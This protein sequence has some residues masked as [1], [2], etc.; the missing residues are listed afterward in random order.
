MLQKW[1]R[2]TWLVALS[3]AFLWVISM[4]LYILDDQSVSWAVQIFP[5][6]NDILQTVYFLIW[7][8]M[9]VHFG[10][11]KSNRYLLIST[12]HFV[13]WIFIAVGAYYAY[14]TTA[15]PG[16]FKFFARLH[17]FIFPAMRGFSFYMLLFVFLVHH[18]LCFY[19]RRA[20]DRKITAKDIVIP[21]CCIVLTAALFI[22]YAITAYR[23]DCEKVDAYER[24][25]FAREYFYYSDGGSALYRGMGYNIMYW[26]KLS[27]EP[28]IYMCGNER[29]FFWEKSPDLSEPNVEL[30]K[31]YD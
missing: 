19:F 8:V 1:S 6:V 15:G 26:H 23:I 13:Y 9:A 14:H 21:A 12:I 30:T 17:I 2:N 24:P 29:W 7:M 25:V 10:R 28:Y 20:G 18:I 22:T 16:W 31:I 3:F 4:I 27:G 11:K 5:Q